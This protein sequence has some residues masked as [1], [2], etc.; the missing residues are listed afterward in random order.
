MRSVIDGMEYA[1]IGGPLEE[2]PCGNCKGPQMSTRPAN[3]QPRLAPFGS[4]KPSRQVQLP[5]RYLHTYAAYISGLG[6]AITGDDLELNFIAF[7]EGL[8]PVHID[9]R[10]MAED[11]FAIGPFDKAVALVIAE[12]L[13]RTTFHYGKTS[14]YI[15]GTYWDRG[16]LT[17]A[18][19]QMP[20]NLNVE[21]LPA[22]MAGQFGTGMAGHRAKW[23]P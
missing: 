3:G 11:I 22:E 2:L 4:V 17:L 6:A 20:V 8:E 7:V 23:A 5:N 18:C 15:R 1:V 9:S 16:A 12:P 21:R 19:P 13:N 14:L 10:V